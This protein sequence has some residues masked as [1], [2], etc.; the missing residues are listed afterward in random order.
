MISFLT[1][2][3]SFFKKHTT[4]KSNDLKAFFGKAQHSRLSSPHS[5]HGIFFVFD[6]T[7]MRRR[8]HHLATYVTPTRVWIAAF[9]SK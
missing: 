1:V 9:R 6:S 2:L 3:N 4:A 8:C 5:K 7:A